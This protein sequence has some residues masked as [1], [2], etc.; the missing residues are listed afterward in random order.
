MNYK[1][2]ARLKCHLIEP[3]TAIEG[4]IES[5]SAIKSYPHKISNKDFAVIYNSVS[6]LGNTAC[7][8]AWKHF[9][10]TMNQESYKTLAGGSL[11]KLEL[12]S[13]V[14]TKEDRNILS[15]IDDR[16]K[17]FIK[18]SKAIFSDDSFHYL[19]ESDSIHLIHKLG[20]FLYTYERI[21]L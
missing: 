14:F 21:I 19:T 9:N 16:A 17:E 13:V 7:E 5:L 3:I 4:A 8:Y 11:R 10:F 20:E 6:A 1:N 15:E 2:R 12:I 18:V